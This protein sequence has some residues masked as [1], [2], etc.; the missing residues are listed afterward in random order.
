VEYLQQLFM[1]L[2]PWQWLW[3]GIY[4]FYTTFIYYLA[5]MNL[6]RSRDKLTW[7]VLV[8]AYPA[9]VVGRTF[10]AI[11]TTTVGTVLFFDLPRELQFSHRLERYCTR[12]EY[13]GTKRRRLAVW[14]ARHFLDP[15][16]PR[17]YH[18]KGAS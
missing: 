8:L 6:K 12:A 1:W 14:L 17:G 11:L 9:L 13:R 7:P 16:D 2:K 4:V 3:D 5:L 15:F 10:N 18:I